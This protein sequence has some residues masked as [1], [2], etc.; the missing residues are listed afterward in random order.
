[1]PLKLLDLRGTG[2]EKLYAAPL[3]LIRPDQF[4][5]WRGANADAAA[6]IRTVSG[7]AQGQSVTGQL[8]VNT[9]RSRGNQ[10]QT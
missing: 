1:M 4:V 2:L 9:A 5:A 6:L 10:Q 7:N 3:A 8:P